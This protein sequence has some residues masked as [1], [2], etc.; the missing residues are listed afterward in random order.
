MH[1]LCSSPKKL[2]MTLR[3]KKRIFFVGNSPYI[4]IDVM[5][6]N[7]IPMKYAGYFG[8]D[9]EF[10]QHLPKFSTICQNAINISNYTKNVYFLLTTPS[11]HLTRPWKLI[12]FLW[13]LLGIL[14]MLVT[15][16]NIYWHFQHFA[17]LSPLFPT[18]AYP[19]AKNK[20]SRKLMEK[21]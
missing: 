20:K 21:D 2:K 4:H 18:K 11:T 6:L 7:S 15:F 9:S 12:P 14:G 3:S 5:Q 16:T 1:A 8:G 17:N 19:D 13:N 10:N